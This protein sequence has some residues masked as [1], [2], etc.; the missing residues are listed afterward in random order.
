MTSPVVITDDYILLNLEETS[1]FDAFRLLFPSNLETTS[2]FVPRAP[3]QQPTISFGHRWSFFVSLMVQKLLISWK[4]PMALVGFV[5]EFWLNLFSGNGGLFNLLLNL[6]TCKLWWPNKSSAKFTTVIGQIDTRIELDKN[7]KPD[8][9]KYKPVLAMMAAKISYENEAFIETNIRQC[10]KVSRSCCFLRMMVCYGSMSM[11]EV[12]VVLFLVIRLLFLALVA[13][14]PSQIRSAVPV[15][16]WKLGFLEC[17]STQ[18]FILQD[19]RSNPNLIVVAFRG[20]EP[21]DADD[22]RADVDLS[23]HKFGDWGCAHWGFMNALGMQNNGWPQEIQQSTHQYAYYTLREKLKEVLQKNE[24]AK[25]ILTGHSL[26]GALA[27]LFSAVLMLHEE[28]WLLERLD[29][30]YTFGQPR[31]GNKDFAD[32]MDKKLTKYDVKYLR[33]VYCHDIVPRLPFDDKLF[34]FKHFGTCLYVNSFYKE[35]CV[36]EL[37]DKNYF[38]LIWVFPLMVVAYWELMRGFIIPYIE[39]PQY[40]E[41][42]VCK[43]WRMTGL[44]VPGMAA[45]GPQDYDNST[46]L[47]SLPSAHTA[48]RLVNR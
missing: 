47:A 32:S 45:H 2:L 37:P 9:E 40:K 17:N 34:L 39:G 25:F 3:W 10:W 33:Y 24:E 30:V 22:W 16:S 4:T 36:T 23:I 6:V 15:F 46:R 31:V 43:M 7:I 41:G 12:A 11:V 42:L 27:I 48:S 18:A 20:T 13:S 5:L 21:F 38:S 8:N 19:T 35:K 26:G 29:G 28:E 14:G 44:V 1:F